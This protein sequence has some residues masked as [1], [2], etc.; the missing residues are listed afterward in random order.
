M[1]QA[2]LFQSHS[3]T[4]LVRRSARRARVFRMAAVAVCGL[5]AA[6]SDTLTQPGSD[7]AVAKLVIETPAMTVASL[8]QA[9]QVEAR[10]VDRNG[11][12]ISEIT[13]S[14]ASSDSSV[15]VHEGNGRFRAL[16]NGTAEVR[17]GIA[18]DPAFPT[19]AAVVTVRQ[20]AARVVLSADT[21]RLYAVGQMSRL[22]A[23]VVDA[24]GT[25]VIDAATPVWSSTDRRVATVDSSGTVIA[26]EDGDVQIA[27]SLGTLT[28]V[29]TARVRSAIRVVGC[30]SAGN[31]ST[32]SCR[33]VLLSTQAAR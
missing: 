28:S 29:S 21:V 18:T 8:N 4:P 23:R 5:Q 31:V 33:T 14:W 25:D 32:S 11:A 24:L 7:W 19:T 27:A 2:H 16:R 17:V 1:Q 10:P 30:V 13:L 26:H 6:C 12:P 3:A 15:L 20:Q 22:R 9:I